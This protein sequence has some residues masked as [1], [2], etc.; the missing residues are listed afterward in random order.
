[1]TGKVNVVM[2]TFGIASISNAGRMAFAVPP[3]C[4][5]SIVCP[6]EMAAIEKRGITA[7]SAATLAHSTNV[8]TKDDPPIQLRGVRMILDPP[9]VQARDPR[10]ASV[11]DRVLV[12]DYGRLV[13]RGP[14]AELERPGS[15]PATLRV[16]E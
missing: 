6:A 13:D 11:F 9:S 12:M 10:L 1:V 2:S 14:C 15:S 5:K 4:S 7:A 3:G 8:A 16:A